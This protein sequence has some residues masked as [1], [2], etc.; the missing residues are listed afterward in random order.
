MYK[1]Q[2][3]GYAATGHSSQGATVD[4]ARVVAGV[5]NLDKASVYVPMTRGREG[6]FL[7]IAE[8]Q[9]GDTETGHGQVNQVARRE[10][11]EYARDLLVS[12]GMREQGDKTPQAL[13]GQA[14]QDWELT[15][16]VNQPSQTDTDNPFVGTEMGEYMR[17][18]AAKREARFADF[19]ARAQANNADEVPEPESSNEHSATPSND[20][21]ESI[22]AEIERVNNQLETLRGEYDQANQQVKQLGQQYSKQ[23]AV[24]REFEDTKNSRGFFGRL[25][26]GNNDQ[27]L[28]D[29]AINV[30]DKVAASYDQAVDYR[31]SF[32]VPIRQL[33]TELDELR[34]Q[35]SDEQGLQ[36][37]LDFLDSLGISS[38]ADEA[39]VAR[40]RQQAAADS[41]YDN[42]QDNWLDDTP[43]NDSPEL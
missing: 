25:R 18:F 6:N 34:S 3:L 37:S 7:Y 4:V 11:A 26:H 19:H 32:T 35:R 12:A 31:D 24:V 14:K 17:S 20:A 27:A 15:K 22:D 43:E 10:S 42:D 21:V 23:D 28:L 33:E 40:I 30:R 8:T 13:F 9:P 2:Q 29:E 36:N 38:T 16:L 5:D 39:M 41:D 1:R